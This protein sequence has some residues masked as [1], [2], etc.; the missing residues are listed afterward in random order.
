MLNTPIPR[1]LCPVHREIFRQWR[2]NHYNPHHPSDWPGGR[3][4][5][6]SRTTHADR[7]KTWDRLNTKQMDLS[8]EICRSGRS[9]QCWRAEDVEAAA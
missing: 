5:L 8:A 7:E 3:A 6:D 2:E 9:P 4:L 1:D